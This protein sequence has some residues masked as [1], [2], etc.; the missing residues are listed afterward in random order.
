[1]YCVCYAKL[2]MLHNFSGH[3][4]SICH[5]S[6]LYQLYHF[7]TYDVCDI[8]TLVSVF[9]VFLAGGGVSSPIPLE[10]I[11][12]HLHDYNDFYFSS[13][14]PLICCWTFWQYSLSAIVYCYLGSAHRHCT[15]HVTTIH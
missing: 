3:K 5:C 13:S 6:K 1:M 2:D 14:L 9:F 10:A 8:S 4:F 7:I 12:Q 11:S 15:F